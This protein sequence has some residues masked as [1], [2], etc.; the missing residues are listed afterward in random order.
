MKTLYLRI[1]K[2]LLTQVIKTVYPFE[3]VWTAKTPKK[4]EYFYPDDCKTIL[5]EFDDGEEHWLIYKK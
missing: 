2:I 4:K 1:R 5:A 3:I